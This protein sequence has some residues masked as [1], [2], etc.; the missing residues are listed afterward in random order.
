MKIEIDPAA[1]GNDP[2]YRVYR[3][4]PA[5]G[6]RYK[7]AV[8]VFT[9][10]DMD[11]LRDLGKKDKSWW[12]LST[13]DYISTDIRDFIDVCVKHGAENTKIKEMI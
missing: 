1:S 2:E 3:I 7:R 13:M 5:T 11:K 8:A 4:N 9:S 10:Q 12:D 6:E